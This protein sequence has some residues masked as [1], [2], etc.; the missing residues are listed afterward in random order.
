MP[1]VAASVGVASIGGSESVVL[2]YL[3]AC[4][5]WMPVSSGAPPVI[6][7]AENF[8]GMVLFSL[9]ARIGL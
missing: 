6:Q 9:N 2:L 4:S 1:V 8:T 3:I 7:V 5:V